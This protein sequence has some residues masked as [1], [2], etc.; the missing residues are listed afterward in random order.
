[1]CTKEDLEKP[2][3]ILN[4]TDVILSCSR[5]RIN[6]K[7]SF[8]KLINLTVVAVLLK[9]V[10]LICKDAVLPKALLQTCAIICLTFKENTKQP[11]NDIFC[12]SCT[13]SPYARKST[14]GRRNFENLQ[15]I[16]QKREGVSAS[17]F[18][19]IYM[20]DIPIVEELFT[21]ESLL[22]DI[23]IVDGNITGELPRR[24]VQNYDYTTSMLSEIQ[25]PSM[26]R[27][28]YY[29]SLPSCSLH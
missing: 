3:V 23:D 15:L 21:L 18:Q 27:E 8:Y 22:H 10:L 16:Q 14:I 6:T 1:M 28:Q 4:K 13:C 2:K 26:L 11:Y 5:D 9:D 17:Q 19:G 24:I 12:L 20:I 25:Q 29:C 7:W